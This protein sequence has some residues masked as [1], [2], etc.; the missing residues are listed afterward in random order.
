MANQPQQLPADPGRPAGSPYARLA[1]RVLVPVLRRLPGGGR[2]QGEA[3]DLTAAVPP[4]VAGVFG[5]AGAAAG[6]LA[7]VFAPVY[8][9]WIFSPYLS[10]G[11]GSVLRTAT[12]LWLYGHG[13]ALWRT[14]IDGASVP[15]GVTPLLLS[16]VFL[17]L[18]RRAAVRADAGG[19]ASLAAA[20]APAAGYLAVGLLAEATWVTDAQGG[21]TV[22][23]AAGF[24]WLVAWVAVL[25][26]GPQLGRLREPVRERL[27]GRGRYGRTGGPETGGSR[28]AAYSGCPRDALRAARAGA[29]ALL[30]AGAAV[31]LVALLAHFGDGGRIAGQLAPDLSGR[32][33]LLLICAAFAPNAAVGGAAAAVG[34]GF[35][36]PGGGLIAFPLLGAVPGGSV[37]GG[38]ALGVHLVL[39]PGLGLVVGPATLAALPA[40]VVVGL[41]ARRAQR[42][43][44][45][46]VTVLLAALGVGLL[47]GFGAWAAGGELGV[48]A[49]A[50]IGPDPLAT[51]GCAAGWT[52]LAGLPAV[53]VARGGLGALNPAGAL[54][55]EFWTALPAAA[56][57][58]P[59]RLP[60]LRRRASADGPAAYSPASEEPDGSD[61]GQ[62]GP[63]RSPAP[64]ARSGPKT[65]DF[66][67]TLGG[68]LG[69]LLD[70]SPDGPAE[71]EAPPLPDERTSR[72][73]RWRDSLR[74]RTWRLTSRGRR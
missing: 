8:L 40:G 26:G 45:A 12:C 15:V 61:A 52:A 17:V 66:D 42:L 70:G 4:V 34:A 30:G 14:G 6:G 51:A 9:L 11:A 43:R 50:W 5:G 47:A 29:V 58:L 18:L 41:F 19:E 67:G 16:A 32:M 3:R 10:G 71:Q 13:A 63:G 62:E 59:Q 57:T 54:R 25:V 56:L 22:R 53:V 39:G 44:A 23:A 69:D 7:L 31:W 64:D 65:G 21:V 60:G 20:L 55:R 2:S 48:N 73:S 1:V 72:I 38:G 28:L 46:L 35:P 74:D 36:V 24:G 68:A 33:A 37:G 27:A 49:L